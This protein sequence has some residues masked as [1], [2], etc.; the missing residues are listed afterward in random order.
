MLRFPAEW[1]ATSSHRIRSS[2]DMQFSFSYF[3]YLMGQT[4]NA[5][6]GKVFEEMDSDKSG[7]LSDRELRTLATRL[8]DLPLE[9]S[10]LTQLEDIIINCSMSS[11][12]NSSDSEVYYNKKMVSLS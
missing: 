11:I 10:M 8:Y 7:V 1:E 12:N 6:V 5:S 4:V 9:L 2:A 3:Y